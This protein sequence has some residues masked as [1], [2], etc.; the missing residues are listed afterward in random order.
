MSEEKPLLANQLHSAVVTILLLLPKDRSTKVVPLLKLAMTP[1]TDVVKMVYHQQLDLN[2]LVVPKLIVRTVFTAVVLMAQRLHKETTTKV[3]YLNLNVLRVSLDAVLII[4]QRLLGRM[5]RVA[6]NAKE[7]NLDVALMEQV[8]P[9]VRK[10]K[11]V[12]KSIAQILHLAVVR[13]D[14]ML[15]K[16]NISK[17]AILSTKRTVLLRTMVAVRMDLPLLLVPSTKVAVWLVKTNNTAAVP[18]A[19]QQ[20][21]ALTKKDVALPTLTVAVLITSYQLVVRT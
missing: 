1:N 3:V 19:S 15:Q 13:M 16:E 8:A 12:R 10:T 4:R 14:K 18:T 9:K 20:P 5:K 21:M 11:D 2:L 6:K 17:G 7:A